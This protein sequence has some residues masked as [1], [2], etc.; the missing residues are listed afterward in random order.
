MSSFR[1]AIAVGII[2]TTLI[3]HHEEISE[4]LKTFIKW[5]KKRFGQMENYAEVHID[6][7]DSNHIDALFN[8]S[9]WSLL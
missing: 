5:L 9:I 6:A 4:K 7:Q 1:T 8:D 2:V 3:M